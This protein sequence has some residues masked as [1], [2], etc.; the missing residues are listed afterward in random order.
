MKRPEIP[1]D[2][3]GD[4]GVFPDEKWAKSLP[5]ICA[6]L[7]DDSWED[8]TSRE[9]STLGIKVE[10]GR[11]LLSIN[12]RALSRSLYVSGDGVEQALKSLEKSLSGGGSDWRYWGGKGKKKK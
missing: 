10:D 1:Q 8:G 2:R 3:P 11:I 5:T 12:D 9:V 6:Y 7:L 4:V